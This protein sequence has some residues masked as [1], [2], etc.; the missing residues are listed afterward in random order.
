M[1]LG[2]IEICNHA[3]LKV[4]ADTIASLD[5]SQATDDGVIFSAKLCN[6]LFDQA[7]VETLRLYPWNSATKRTQLTRLAETPAFKYQFKYALPI[8]FV[9]VINLYASTEAY[10]DTTEWSVE[11]GEV[12]TDYEE[13]YLKYVAKPEDVSIL[14]PLAQ[15]AV[16][17][18]LA[19]KLA[20]PMHLDE[21]LK[22]NLLTELQTIIL[23]AA[24]SI[25]TIENKNWDNEES[26][27]LVS[28]NYSSPI[29]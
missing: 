18:S 17:C 28:R 15:Q 2:K 12:L 10:D 13:A 8:D 19:M 14:D 7:L 23:P 1:A 6:I 20:V 29:I 27:F 11:S 3:L 25:D 26:N 16:I 24:R 22:N 21:K 9:R 5:V 4:G